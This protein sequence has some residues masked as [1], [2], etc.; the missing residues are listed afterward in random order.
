MHGIAV[1]N[2]GKVIGCYLVFGLHPGF[3]VGSA[4]VFQPAVRIGYSG[5][6]ISIN[7]INLFG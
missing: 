5:V 1:G 4:V 2:L 6:K 3:G 7:G